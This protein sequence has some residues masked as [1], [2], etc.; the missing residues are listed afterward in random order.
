MTTRKRGIAPLCRPM[1]RLAAALGH[2][3]ARRARPVRRPVRCARRVEL[4]TTTGTAATTAPAATAVSRA[5][6]GGTPM[7]GSA[8]PPAP[9][10]CV[11]VLG[12]S[13][14]CLYRPPL[15]SCAAVARFHASTRCRGALLAVAAC[16]PCQPRVPR[17]SCP[18]LGGDAV[19]GAVCGRTHRTRLG[20]RGASSGACQAASSGPCVHPERRCGADGLL[21]PACGA[22]VVCAGACCP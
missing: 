8:L 9:R 17:S 20:R 5:T 4:T 19:A 10:C 13:R 7:I 6:G 3:V 2:H 21:L 16:M 12:H 11:G 1:S 22:C 14:E 15:P 18:A